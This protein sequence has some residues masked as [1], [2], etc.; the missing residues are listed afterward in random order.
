MKVNPSDR[1]GIRHLR[2][3]RA[4]WPERLTALGAAQACTLCLPIP[5]NQ[6]TFHDD[7]RLCRPL[8]SARRFAS[9][10]F[11]IGSG[12]RKHSVLLPIQW[13]SPASERLIGALSSVAQELRLLAPDPRIEDLNQL[14]FPD[15]L[16]GRFLS[17]LPGLGNRQRRKRIFLT[18]F[19]PSCGVHTQQSRHPN[20]PDWTSIFIAVFHLMHPQS[21]CLLNPFRKSEVIQDSDFRRKSRPRKNGCFSSLPPGVRR[22]TE[23]HAAA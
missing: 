3:H 20:E 7:L 6:L 2:L 1:K 12:T 19:K 11:P 8:E 15:L 9:V 13:Q 21:L 4:H 14:G 22:P 17:S 18:G 23:R 5:S 16:V 10:P